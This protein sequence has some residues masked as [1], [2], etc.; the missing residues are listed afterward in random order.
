MK[1]EL[2][3]TNELIPYERNQK[4]HDER[5]IRN[6]A[7][8]IKRFG[9]QQPIVI[10]GKGVVVIGHCRLLAAQMLG[11]DE[12]PVTVADGLTEDEIRELRIADNK[13]NESEWDWEKLKIDVCEL[14][15]DGFDFNFDEFVLDDDGES[16]SAVE[17][18][19]DVDEPVEP[20]S[21]P[22]D[23]YQLGNHRLM[24][25]DSTNADDVNK[26]MGGQKADIAFT[27]PPYGVADSA[28][29]RDHYVKGAERDK[30]FYDGYDD[31]SDQWM[32]LIEKS[33]AN[34]ADHSE[35]QFIN[36]QML[37]DNK[38]DLIRFV[39]EHGDRLADI[40]MWDKQKAP[41][42]MQKNILNNEYEF[43]FVFGKDGCPRTI[44]H[45]AFHGNMSNII[46]IP[47]G[48]ND[49]ADVHRAVFPV[50]LPAEIL[51][52]NSNAKSVMD[53][54]G[55]TGTT[56]IAAE[57]IGVSCYMMELMPKYVDLI[58]ARWEQFTG[59]K[60]ELISE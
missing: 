3:K 55:G 29:I 48:I 11:L 1:I 14:K 40:V 19:F 38:R 47:V 39:S 43:I 12:V 57:Q 5:Q 52:M 25:G 50:A 35:Q 6:V 37:A 28:K 22:G 41:P 44:E 27:S 45:G 31:D 20:R 2:R 56:M 36:I 16:A 60:A 26:L 32:N 42:Q 58:I 24:C 51:A 54:F 18:D 9:W 33:Y 53:L 4:K 15:F 7:N 49:Y 8:S 17:D 10:D 34:M 30:S 13:T 23:V 21:K 59:K 46:R